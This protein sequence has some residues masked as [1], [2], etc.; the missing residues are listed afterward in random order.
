MA[1]IQQSILAMVVIGV[2]LVSTLAAG[3]PV[4]AG[5]RTINIAAS[6]SLKPAF[7]EILLMFEKE[8]GVTVQVVYGPSQTLRR[9]IEQ[10][11]PFDVFL[12]ESME[13]VEKLEKKGLTLNGGPRIYGKSSLVLVMSAASRA[14]AISFHDALPNRGTRI[15][16]ADPKTSALGQITAR[17]LS[18]FNPGPKSSANLVYG[19]HSDD[20]MNLVETGKA[21]V[22]IVYRADAI[23]SGRMRIIDETPAGTHTSVFLGQAVV[24]TCRDASREAAE[25][26]FDFMLSPRIQMML[27]QHGFD[28]VPS[29]DHP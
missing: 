3:D 9:Q 5:D 16:L 19:E 22:G 24:S 6:H 25:K 23:S 27:L 15:A 7:H 14:M 4:H 11:A 20:V 2:L 10:G 8:Y 29:H 21:D 12:P 18:K 17:A 1:R 13:E 28:P 26:F